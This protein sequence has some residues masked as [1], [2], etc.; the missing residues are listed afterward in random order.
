M[1]YHFFTKILS[2]TILSVLF[3]SVGILSDALPFRHGSVK[4]YTLLTA[5]SSE[6][7][8][9]FLDVILMW[10]CACVYAAYL[11][12]NTSEQFLFNG[13]PWAGFWY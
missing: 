6:R 8:E 9:P 13:F 1:S 3:I 2:L 12:N 7:L 11:K 5:H 4:L 10:L